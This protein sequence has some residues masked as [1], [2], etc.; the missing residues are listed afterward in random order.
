[1]DEVD[2]YNASDE[3]STFTPEGTVNVVFSQGTVVLDGDL[4]HI[5]YTADGAHLT[6]I[7][8]D[9]VAI[10]YVLSGSS[11][12]GFFKLYSEKKQL[13]ELSSLSLTNPAGAACI[14]ADGDFVMNGGVLTCT[15]TGSGGKGISC[16]GTGFFNGG[17][18]NASAAGTDFT[19]G[20]VHPKAIKCDGDIEV[21]GGEITVSSNRHEAMTTGGAW[22]QSGGSVIADA[23]DDAVNSAGT[24][25]ITGGC[26]YGHGTNNDGI[27]ANAAIYISGGIVIGVGAKAPETGIDSVEGTTVTVS[28]GYVISQGGDAGSFSFSNDMACVSTTLSSGTKIA[29][30][31]GSKFLM[32]YA[33]P[34]GGTSAR[35]ITPDLKSG[36]SYTL[37]KGVSFTPQY[38][39]CFAVEG[40]SGGSASGT[41]SASSASS[42]GGPGGGGHGPGGR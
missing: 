15:A 19:K 29:L 7:N 31:D 32:A 11:S 18:V 37:Y 24:M 4:D 28:G 5:T 3:V 35:I 42:G 41:L 6:V 17:T 22:N 12:D 27:D 1:M 40:I 21:T 38:L 33:V 26:L 30:Y 9:T 10:K 14:K 23:Y 13:L 36:S 25:T 39:G 34:S 8:K 20:S 16:D 2:P